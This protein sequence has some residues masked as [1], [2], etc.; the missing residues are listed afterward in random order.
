M[1]YCTVQDLKD[2]GL[3]EEALE[4]ID[5]TLLQG[6]LDT[7][8]GVIDVYLG[9]RYTLPLVA[10]Y[11]E[12]LRRVNIDLAVCE[13]FLYRGFNPEEYDSN[14]MER[15]DKWMAMLEDI[16]SGRLN[17]PGIEDQTPTISESAPRVQTSTVRGW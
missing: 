9:S 5:D 14:Y 12:F 8:Q 10:P 16:S 11:P 15:C 2:L 7:T 1:A 6:Q 4:E 17:V 3:P 13:I